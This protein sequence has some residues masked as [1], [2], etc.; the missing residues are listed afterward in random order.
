MW[1]IFHHKAPQRMLSLVDLNIQK[2]VEILNLWKCLDSLKPSE[3]C[4]YLFFV[5]RITVC[6][7]VPGA[8]H[9]GLYRLPATMDPFVPCLFFSCFFLDFPQE[10]ISRQWGLAPRFVYCVIKPHILSFL[11]FAFL[12]LNEKN[13][14]KIIQEKE[15]AFRQCNQ[16]TLE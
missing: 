1:R 14:E 16:Q 13:T 8:L 5:N 6:C 7:W 12:P 4:F 9:F 3:M 10:W 2:E 15:P 11:C